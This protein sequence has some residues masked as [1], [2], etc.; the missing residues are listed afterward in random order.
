MSSPEFERDE[1]WIRYVYTLAGDAVAHGGDQPFAA[2]LVGPGGELLDE[3]VNIRLA[4]LVGHAETT[5]MRRAAARY[6]RDEMATLTLY[7]STEPCLMCAGAIAWAGPGTLVYGLS[8]ARMNELEW[9]TPPRF[10]RPFPVR[11]LLAGLE[12]PI[13]I[14]GPLLEK[15]GLAVHR[16]F[17][18]P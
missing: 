17:E 4:D 8:Q 18:W 14:R 7:S 11:E 15:E 6:G 12:T 10:P 2:A 1:Q 13:V 3:A 9:E 5:V 16:D